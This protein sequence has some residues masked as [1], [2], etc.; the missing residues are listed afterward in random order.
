MYYN[1]IERMNFSKY[2][3]AEKIICCILCFIIA[4]VSLIWTFNN[5]DRVPATPGDF[6]ELYEQLLAVQENPDELIKNEGTIIIYNDNII[7]D[8]E[9][10]EC[11]MTGK[12]TR[13]FKLIEYSQKDKACSLFV[14]ILLTIVFAVIAFMASFMGLYIIIFIGE[15][16]TIEIILLV[17]KLRR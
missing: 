5:I 9:N 15:S 2:N 3:S 4:I 11:K 6:E 10:N 13:D 17:K 7:Y 1:F 8:I 14:S 12:Y 16:I